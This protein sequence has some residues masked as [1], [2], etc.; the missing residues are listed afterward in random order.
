MSIKLESG[1]EISR[2]S[3]VKYEEIT[4]EISYCGQPLAQI[5]KDRGSDKLEIEIY[6]EYVVEPLKPKF[7]FDV[8]DFLEVL[9]KACKI[10]K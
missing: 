2:Y 8:I 5:N 7:T 4:A 3:D 9:D 10:L 6:S 1:F